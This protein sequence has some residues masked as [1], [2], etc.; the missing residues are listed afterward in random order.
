MMFCLR[1]LVSVSLFLLVSAK[2][3]SAASAA[4]LVQV[5][6][7]AMELSSLQDPFEEICRL[8][9]SGVTCA[10]KAFMVE[11]GRIR[12]RVAI[13][14][15]IEQNRVVGWLRFSK[16][17][18]S[19]AAVE[20]DMSTLFGK[21]SE[22]PGLSG[23]RFDDLKSQMILSLRALQKKSHSR[24]RGIFWSGVENGNALLVFLPNEK[25]GVTEVGLLIFGNVFESM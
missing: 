7:H 13:M 11:E 8:A 4:P 5:L 24:F 22:A 19:R 21:F 12:D 10:Y 23:E 15:N 14:E 3:V 25:F 17:G 18:A 6:H 9:G 1:T 16:R 2:G 20:N